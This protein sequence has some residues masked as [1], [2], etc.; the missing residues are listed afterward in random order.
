MSLCSRHLV[1]FLPCLVCYSG[2]YISENPSLTCA[3]SRLVLLIL[4]LPVIRTFHP[5]NTGKSYHQGNNQAKDFYRFVLMMQIRTRMKLLLINRL[6]QVQCFFVFSFLHGSMSTKDRTRLEGILSHLML[7]DKNAGDL[8]L[9][10]VHS[11]HKTSECLIYL[12]KGRSVLSFICILN[13]TGYF[14]RE[15][16]HS[17]TMI[18]EEEQ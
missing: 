9:S 14:H 7:L 15:S 16:L 3:A 11:T 13:V 12:L 6:T 18:I 2:S 1:L 8:H 10:L 4:F 5:T 17:L